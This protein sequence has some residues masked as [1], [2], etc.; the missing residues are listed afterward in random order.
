MITWQRCPC[1]AKLL[2]YKFMCSVIDGLESVIMTRQ[3]L[4]NDKARCLNSVRLKADET[5]Y[6]VRI[7]I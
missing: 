5:N 7:Q 3:N 1:S 6:E 4:C 2:F